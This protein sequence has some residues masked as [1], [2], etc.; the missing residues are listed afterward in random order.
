MRVVTRA[1]HQLEADVVRLGFLLA[2]ERQLE[3]HF[4]HHV[5]HVRRGVTHA[6]DRCRTRQHQLLCIGARHTFARVFTQGVCDFV[7]EH[8][9]DLG[10]G[11][12]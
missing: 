5:R 10:I 2:A 11:Q 8:G 3:R 9:G 1:R 7:T 6:G 4:G 12:V